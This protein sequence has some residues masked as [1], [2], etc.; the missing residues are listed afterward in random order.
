MVEVTPVTPVRTSARERRTVQSV[1]RA[2][3]ILEALSAS[4][5]EMQLRDIAPVSTSPPATTF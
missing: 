2:I 1:E 4:D 3:D 5:G